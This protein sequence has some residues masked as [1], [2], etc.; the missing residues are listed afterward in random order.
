MCEAFGE[1]GGV[2]LPSVP[3]IVEATEGDLVIAVG[4]E[5]AFRAVV[6]IEGV[7]GGLVCAL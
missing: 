5:G 4:E 1:V 3:T 7:V 6:E 2:N